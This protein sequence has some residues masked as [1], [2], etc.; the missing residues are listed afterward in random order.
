M[1][2]ASSNHPLAVNYLQQI[3][4]CSL[5]SVKFPKKNKI[6]NLITQNKINPLEEEANGI[7]AYFPSNQYEFFDNNGV[8]ILPTQM[9]MD[10]MLSTIYFGNNT[11]VDNQT[12]NKVK[13]NFA[14]S[15]VLQ[16]AVTE[17]FNSVGE[18]STEFG[19]LPDGLSIKLDQGFPNYTQPSVMVDITQVPSTIAPVILDVNSLNGLPTFITNLE[20][21]AEAGLI[22]EVEEGLKQQLILNEDG[23]FNEM[24]SN[25]YNL[26][27]KDPSGLYTVA[28]ATPKKQPAQSLQEIFL[29]YINFAQTVLD[30]NVTREGNETIVKDQNIAKDFNQ[31]QSNKLFIKS[32]VKG[33][34]FFLDVTQYGSISLSAKDKVKGEAAELVGTA[35][36]VS[37]THLTLPTTPYV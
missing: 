4:D 15:N 19:K 18:G 33:R 37:Y 8:E 35:K 36:S 24:P 9:S 27:V 21:D 11:A 16:T 12:L 20:G 14:T 31:K 1:N 30:T 10:F 26:V 2:H 6:D 17:I 34:R 29:E 22:S 7:F 28:T 25:R 13:D 3:S 5:D 23:A 32:D